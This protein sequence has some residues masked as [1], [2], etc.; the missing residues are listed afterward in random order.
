QGGVPAPLRLPGGG[1][2]QFGAQDAALLGLG[3]GGRG[4]RH[5]RRGGE[6]GVCCHACPSE[7]RGPGDRLTLNSRT[8]AAPCTIHPPSAL[9][10][11][12]RTAEP[13]PPARFR[14]RPMPTLDVLVR[15]LG[16]DL[17][18]VAPD[19]PP[20]REVTGVHVSELIDP[21]PYLSGGELLL[22]TGMGLTGQTAQARAYTARLAG[23]GTAAL[24]LGLGP[25]HAEVP[26]TL[27][28]ACR[29]AG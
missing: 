24:G 10:R 22:T 13:P 9:P 17:A 21:T 26:P 15:T 28:D 4:G 19:R 3:E 8:P 11:T 16:D 12:H 29:V 14:S 1:A 2:G 25:L 6:C 5:G 20:A 27:V 7:G 23:H 18:P